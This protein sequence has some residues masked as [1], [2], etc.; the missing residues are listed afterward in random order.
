MSLKSLD[1]LAS[2]G[3]DGI[4]FDIKGDEKVYKDYLNGAKVDIIWR[5]AKHAL[6]L[7]IH[8][9]MINLIIPKVNDNEETIKDLVEIHLKELGAEV[10]IHF[11]RYYP[12]YKFKISPTSI[13]TLEKAYEIAKSKGIL[14]PYL[15]NVPG[16][17]YENTY[18]PD[19]GSLL[20]ER[21]G[22]R[23]S[24]INLRGKSCYKCQKNIPIYGSI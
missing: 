24:K 15:G 19:C 18:C 1:A 13:S 3:L 6:N 11:T 4:R 5:N 21:F 23:I 16:H 7:N 14:Y 12:A 9:E 20:I 10:P 8:V 2:S 17:A 22:Y